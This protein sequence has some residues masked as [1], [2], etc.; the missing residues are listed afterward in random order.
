MGAL[1]L[2]VYAALAAGLPAAAAWMATVNPVGEPVTPLTL[3]VTLSSLKLAL[4]MPVVVKATAAGLAW[5]TVTVAWA[6]SST[7]AT[8]RP[9]VVTAVAVDRRLAAEQAESA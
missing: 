6:V 5:V 1:P 9:A 2:R 3:T 8:D 4:R 7:L